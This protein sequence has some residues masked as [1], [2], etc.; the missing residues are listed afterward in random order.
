MDSPYYSLK[1]YLGNDFLELATGG[2]GQLDLLKL[3]HFGATWGVG[4]RWHIKENL[5]FTLDWFSVYIPLLNKEFKADYLEA[6]ASEDK[7][8]DLRDA[9]SLFQDIPSLALFRFQFGYSF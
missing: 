7:K 5:T 2:S 9:I 1:A 6:T 8:K 3:N 4:N